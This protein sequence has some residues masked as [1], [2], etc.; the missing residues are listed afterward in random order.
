MVQE[1]TGFPGLVANSM[2]GVG[3]GRRKAKISKAGAPFYPVSVV[4]GFKF[5]LK[6]NLKIPFF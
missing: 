1:I 2:K 5:L 6:T 3:E 4:L